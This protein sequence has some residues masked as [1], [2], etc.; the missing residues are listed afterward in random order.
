MGNES[1]H[2]YIAT[3]Y[4][5]H[6]RTSTTIDERDAQMIVSDVLI[7]LLISELS[8]ERKTA[9]ISMCSNI[10]TEVTGRE[11]MLAGFAT[12]I[13]ERINA[14]TQMSNSLCNND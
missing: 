2:A 9:L 13:K 4:G 1:I 5:Y 10:F 6:S 3:L 12:P 8:P 11:K 14:I 7:S